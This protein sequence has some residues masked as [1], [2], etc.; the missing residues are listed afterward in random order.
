MLSKVFTKLFII[1]GSFLIQRA[2]HSEELWELRNSN[3]ERSGGIYGFLNSLNHEFKGLD[4]YPVVTWDAGL[5]PRRVAVYDKYKRNHL[6]VAERI[7]RNNSDISKSSLENEMYKNNISSDSIREAME[8]IDEIMRSER[9]SSF[10]SKD[11]DDFR[12]QY[13]RQRDILINIL[14]TLGVPS[15]RINRWE[16]DDL[17]TLLTRMSEQSIVMTD[18][19]DMIQLIAPNIK[20]YRPMA[21]Q[22]LEYDS[23]MKE[24]G[25]DDIKE[26]AIIK[27]ISGDGS[28]NIPS[29]TSG[30]ERKYCLGSTRA[31][32]VAKIILKN[33]RNPEL[34]LKE[35]DNLGKNYY[36]GFIK[37][38]DNY[39]RNMKLV[40]LSLVE[41]DESVMNIIKAEVLS[42]SGKCNMMNAI[43]LLNEQNIL[44]FDTNGFISRMNVLS[45]KVS[46]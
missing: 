25:F 34:Y 35:L 13:G 6:R 20:I 11:P 15:I 2:L 4:Y 37:N 3:G 40:D 10:A 9:A 29:V 26:F 42:K 8:S 21:K 18:D 33:Q 1:D 41:N 46:A 31:K 23:Y 19:R 27:A 12:V 17:I 24:Q 39:I 30:L 44:S 7:M 28:D 38:H 22:H 45:C 5:S 36:K 16:G 14:S 43:Q 32:T